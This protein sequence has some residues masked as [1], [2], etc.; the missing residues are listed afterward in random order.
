VCPTLL[1]AT[2]QPLVGQNANDRGTIATGSRS[3]QEA[4]VAEQT[5]TIKVQADIVGPIWFI[6]WLFTLA[7]ANLGFWQALLA[8]LIWPFFLGNAVG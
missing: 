7:Y 3:V 4:T 1:S 2:R 8:I 5:K 6:G